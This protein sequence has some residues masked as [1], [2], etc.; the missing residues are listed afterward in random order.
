M[1]NIIL[2]LAGALL[3][4]GCTAIFDSNYFAS[5]DTPP[6]V[7]AADMENKTADQLE[8]LAQDP[9][10]FDPLK[11]DT[12]RLALAK[13]QEKL[14]EKFPDPDP[15]VA[16]NAARAYV[17]VTTYS[18]ESSAVVNNFVTALLPS[19]LGKNVNDL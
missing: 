12:T 13:V 7:T 5:V 15:D 10:F 4:S 2:L 18:T 16:A 8:V 17:A 9:T 11:A 3:L 14:I 6:P 1:K 19:V